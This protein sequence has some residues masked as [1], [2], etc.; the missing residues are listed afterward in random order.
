MRRPEELRRGLKKEAA[1]AAGAI[2]KVAISLTSR[3]LWQ[4]LGFKQL[5]GTKEAFPAEPFLGIGFHARP[6]ASGKPE[7]IVLMVGD[8][9]RTPVVVAVRDEATRKAIAST[10]KLD[11]TAM[12]N[13]KSIIHVKDDETIEARSKSGT[14]VSVATVADLQRIISAI[15]TAIAA[16]GGAVSAPELDAL[17]TALQGLIP[18][19]PAG[20]SKFRAE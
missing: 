9:A 15:T 6:P 10:L 4:L 13:S 20:T 17:L 16:L 14:A 11:E 1:H 7:A 19:W 8:D 2:R 3:A 5:D 12:F 18:A